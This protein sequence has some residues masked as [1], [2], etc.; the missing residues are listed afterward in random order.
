MSTQKKITYL[1]PAPVRYNYSTPSMSRRGG[2]K[3]HPI[4]DG[5]L[6]PSSSSQSLRTRDA[7]GQRLRDVTNPQTG[8]YSHSVSLIESAPLNPVGCTEIKSGISPNPTGQLKLLPS[9][10]RLDKHGNKVYLDAAGRRIRTTNMGEIAGAAVPRNPGPSTTPSKPKRSRSVATRPV[11]SSM[12]TVPGGTGPGGRITDDDIR[13]FI[14]AT[15]KKYGRT[16]TVFTPAMMQE[17]RE[18][19]KLARRQAQLAIMRADLA[20]AEGTGTG[21]ASASKSGE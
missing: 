13:G 3:L 14:V 6:N 1:P 16:V 7:F 12:P 19:L 17:G 4:N 2:T 5:V 9:S 18:S 11:K 8:M 15:A 20:A 10:V 21:A